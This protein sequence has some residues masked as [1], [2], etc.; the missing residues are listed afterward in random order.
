V[1]LD[2]FA[3][4]PTLLTTL[5]GS[6]GCLFVNEGDPLDILAG[7]GS[8]LSRSRDGGLSW[9]EIGDGDFGT[10]RDAQSSPVAPN[11]IRVCAGDSLWITYDGGANWVAIIE[12]GALH[13]GDGQAMALATAPWGRG[14][15]FDGTDLDVDA[16]ILFEEGY[17]VGWF[18][19]DPLPADGLTSITP[20]LTEEGFVVGRTADLVRDG[21]MSQLLYSA[22]AGQTWVLRWNGTQFNATLGADVETSEAH[23]VTNLDAAWALDDDVAATSIGYGGTGRPREAGVLILP[24]GASGS[25]DKVWRYNVATAAWVGVTPPQAGW[26]WSCIAATPFNPREWLLL[27]NTTTGI[28]GYTGGNIL[29]ASGTDAVLY[30]TADRGATWTPVTLDASGGVGRNNV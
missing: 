18:G 21:L 19:V 11:E 23:K 30:H 2:N 13:T 1:S 22:G 14:V 26:Y 29:P 10:V 25:A 8:S 6:I 9:T 5:D 24:W 7:H 15:V 17:S 27:G 20:L 12:W 16:M 28:W 3:T 4:T